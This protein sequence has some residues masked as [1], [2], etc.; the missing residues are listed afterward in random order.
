M[1]TRGILACTTMPASDKTKA[2]AT[3]DLGLLENRVEFARIPV[4]RGSQEI[5]PRV[6]ND[7]YVIQ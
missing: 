3:S 1:T 7:D 2:A 4:L 5:P 6:E